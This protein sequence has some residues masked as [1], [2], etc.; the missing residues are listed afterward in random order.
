MSVA[1]ILWRWPLMYHDLQESQLYVEKSH[2]GAKK[3]AWQQQSGLH[4]AQGV[5][6]QVHFQ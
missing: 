6:T 5:V 3:Y 2:P 4:V 1:Q